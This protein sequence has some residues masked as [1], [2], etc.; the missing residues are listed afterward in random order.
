[1]IRRTPNHWTD[2]REKPLRAKRLGGLTL[3]KERY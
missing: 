1:V 3:S 2:G